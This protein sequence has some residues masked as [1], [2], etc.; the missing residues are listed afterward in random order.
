V[1][2]RVRVHEQGIHASR[3][4]SGAVSV[5]PLTRMGVPKG[6]PALLTDANTPTLAKIPGE[7]PPWK[8]KNAAP[9][10]GY[11]ACS[12]VPPGFHSPIAPPPLP[13]AYRVRESRC[14]TKANPSAPPAKGA[15]RD[16]VK[17]KAK[18]LAKFT[19]SGAQA[20]PTRPISEGVSWR[21]E[22]EQEDAE[23]SFIHERRSCA[24]V[25][26]GGS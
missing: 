7:P 5:G 2:L 21:A 3:A 25:A 26:Q 9:R 11:T 19:R 13:H 4:E 22:A 1:V 12:P 6:F 14:R 15:V 10:L 16:M 23:E 8:S 18:G 20:A 17:S 24:A